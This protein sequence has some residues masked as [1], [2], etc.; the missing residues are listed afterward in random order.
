MPKLSAEDRKIYNSINTRNL[1]NIKNNV[2]KYTSELAGHITDNQYTQSVI[3]INRCYSILRGQNDSW[4]LLC[5]T[6]GI[7]LGNDISN[8]IHNIESDLDSYI[9]HYNFLPYKTADRGRISHRFPIEEAIRKLDEAKKSF[10]FK[11]SNIAIATN[12]ISTL[13]AELDIFNELY[14]QVEKSIKYIKTTRSILRK[15]KNEKHKL[16]LCEMKKKEEEKWEQEHGLAYARAAALVGN[17]RERARRVN[18]KI[19][20]TENCPY[21]GRSIGSNPHVDH[22]YP[23][24]RG[25]LSSITNMVYVCNDCNLRKGGKGVL[26]FLIENGYPIE[27]VYKKLRDLGKVI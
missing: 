5:N 13:K 18:R 2:E 21:C 26:E 24:K 17:S 1:I 16:W 11:E 25:G 23:V 14:P 4:A 22:I 19:L 27:E 20:L 9:N 10:F 12:R 3:T 7:A 8:K 6:Y 15:L